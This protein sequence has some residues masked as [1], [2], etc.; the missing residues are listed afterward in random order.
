MHEI[1][2]DVQEY[3]RNMRYHDDVDDDLKSPGCQVRFELPAT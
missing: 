2:L 1:L 3:M